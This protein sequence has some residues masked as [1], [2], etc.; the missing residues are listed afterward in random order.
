MLCFCEICSSSTFYLRVPRSG[1]FRPQGPL[2]NKCLVTR[3]RSK[4]MTRLPS[5][6]L[7]PPFSKKILPRSPLRAIVRTFL[8]D[9]LSFDSLKKWI[10]NK[11]EKEGVFCI[12]SAAWSDN[13]LIHH[14]AHTRSLATCA[15]SSSSVPSSGL[16]W[17]HLLNPP[18]RAV[19]QPLIPVPSLSNQS[20]PRVPLP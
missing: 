18:R 9:F 14:R 13:K 7:L 16:P 4:K 6:F 17:A 10:S 20:T 3:I 12:V 2:S 5:F 8:L 11:F 15:Q 1:Q 19:P